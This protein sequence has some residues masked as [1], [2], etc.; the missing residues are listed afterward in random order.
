MGNTSRKGNAGELRVKRW[1]EERGW[2]VAS[3]RHVGGAA[4]LLCVRRKP[5]YQGVPGHDVHLVEVKARKEPWQGF[6]KPDRLALLAEAESIGAVP[7][8]AWVKPRV[9]EPIFLG[10]E[11][12]PSTRAD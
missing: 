5:A 8:L 3:R 11:H 12:W 6:R 7:L 2:I 10:P 9:R 4:D 1:Y